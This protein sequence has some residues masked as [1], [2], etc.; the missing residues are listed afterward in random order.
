MPED[1]KPHQ[2]YKQ[3]SGAL[4]LFNSSVDESTLSGASNWEVI[5]GPTGQ[6]VFANRS[7]LDLSGWAIKDLT[8]FVQGVDIQKGRLPQLVPGAPYPAPGLNMMIEID[9][10]TTRKI[11]DLELADFDDLPG[12]AGSTMDLMQVIYAERTTYAANLNV[13]GAVIK[14]D[15]ETWGSGVPCATDKLHYSKAVLMGSA[16]TGDYFIIYP[17]NLVLQAMTAKEKD[18]VW[19]E[20]LRRSYV[21]QGEL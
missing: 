5:T 6:T 17:T 8:T 7:Y 12:F 16:I 20:R 19:M 11:T 3:I 21:L 1:V 4:G 15:Y 9:L 2:L 14:L 13:P 18:L 10:I